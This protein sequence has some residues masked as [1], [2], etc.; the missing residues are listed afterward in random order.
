MNLIKI[1]LSKTIENT[2]HTLKFKIDETNRT[3]SLFTVNNDVQDAII[4][5]INEYKS[6]ENLI[7]SISGTKTVYIK[8]KTIKYVDDTVIKHNL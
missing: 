6:V 5:R 1:Y 4:L 3:A 2:S 7:T 8:T